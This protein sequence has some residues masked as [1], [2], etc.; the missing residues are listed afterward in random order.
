M[1]AATN[2]VLPM[3]AP[4]WTYLSFVKYEVEHRGS[5]KKYTPKNWLSIDAINFRNSKIQAYKIMAELLTWTAKQDQ[6]DASYAVCEVL[7]TAGSWLYGYCHHGHEQKEF[8]T[9]VLEIAAG[10]LCYGAMVND[11]GVVIQSAYER[12]VRERQ[13]QQAANTAKAKGT[14]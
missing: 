1:K 3:D 10:W 5:V 14:L 6:T 13:A 8:A 9:W 4:A 11:T 7:K 12:L 2:P